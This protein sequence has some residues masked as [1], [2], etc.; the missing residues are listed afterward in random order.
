MPT[1]KPFSKELLSTD[2]IFG[3]I[4]GIA[5]L[6]EVYKEQ[7]VP[8]DKGNKG[9]SF[10]ITDKVLVQNEKRISTPGSGFSK[11]GIARNQE[12][13]NAFNKLPKKY[14]NSLKAKQS[15][16][17]HQTR[18]K[19][20]SILYWQLII[21]GLRVQ[22]VVSGLDLKAVPNKQICLSSTEGNIIYS[23]KGR[24]SKVS[25]KESAIT[26]AEL[27]WVFR[28]REVANVQ[29]GVQF[30][31]TSTPDRYGL[32]IPCEAPWDMEGSKEAWK[33]YELSVQKKKFQEVRNFWVRTTRDLVPVDS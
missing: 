20:K 16:D 27:R 26:D 18:R 32:P 25:E 11:A 15:E 9:S 19:C 2:M 7:G 8:V 5:S 6:Y 30:W 22:F 28:N 4:K 29:K 1:I 31:K 23:E 17:P 3:T 21:K 12:Y 10:A 33:E 14:E 24:S 13:L